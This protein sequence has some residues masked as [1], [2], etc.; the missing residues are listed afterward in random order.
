ML[1]RLDLPYTDTRARQL[2]WRLG[3]EALPAL[4]ELTVDTPA[5]RLRLRLLGASHQVLVEIDGAPA[6]SETVACGTDGSAL[7]AAA[8]RDLATGSYR[9]TADVRHLSRADFVAEVD[10]LV[11]CLAGR[12]DA[13]VGSYPGDVRAVTALAA[14]AVSTTTVTWRTWHAYPQTGELVTTRTRLRVPATSTT[15]ATAGGEIVSA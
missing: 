6:C 12:T 4:A 2:R 13:L 3:A 14:G 8:E 10:G 7:P 5:V 11:A 1:A 9:L 15:L